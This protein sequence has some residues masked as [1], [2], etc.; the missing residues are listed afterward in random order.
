MFSFNVSN[1]YFRAGNGTSSSSMNSDINLDEF[2]SPTGW[3]IVAAEARLESAQYP[4]FEEPSHMI[5]YTISFKR[6]VYFDTNTGIL[7]RVGINLFPALNIKPRF[8]L[9]IEK[10]LVLSKNQ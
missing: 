3:Q 8:S 1:L 7:K 6:D 9:N 10:I 4:L 2:N 5:V